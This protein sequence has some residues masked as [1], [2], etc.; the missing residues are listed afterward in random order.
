MIAIVLALA[1][2][3]QGGAAAAR[4]ANGLITGQVRASDNSLPAGVRV[5]A[6]PVP[7]GTIYSDSEALG[8]SA[9]TPVSTTQTDAQ[10]RFR[11]ENVPPGRYLVQGGLANNTTYY[12]GVTSANSRTATVVT[13]TAGQTVENIDFRLQGSLGQRVSGRVHLSEGTSPG[14]AATL[15]GSRIEEF[16]SVP[17]GSD[18]T[19]EFARVPPGLYLL[20]TFPPP[21]GLAPIAVPVRTSD[22][23]GLEL[24]SPPTRNVTGRIVMTNGG[25]IPSGILSFYNTQSYVGATVNG[26]GTFTAKLHAARHQVDVAGMPI[27]Y[28][29]VSV[30]I[31]ST[32]AMGG[33]TVANADVSG[34]VVT[35]SAPPSLPR[36]QGKVTGL[37][38]ARLTSAKVELTGP[39][40][41]TLTASIRPD[42]SFEFPIMIPGLYE[43]RLAGVAEFKPIEVVVTDQPLTTVTL[44]VK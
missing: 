10:G 39:I 40:F 2:W 23:T 9:L 20:S 12:P 8:I 30:R 27:G 17:L 5:A 15:T 13:V 3:Q 24:T 33:F 44:T 29:L 16:L 37:T 11:L 31:G 6:I 28:N 25:P 41:G 21:P 32:D 35:V 43:A 26:D 36:L 14:Q 18:G 7:A 38:G 22:V 4:P 42:G 1:L 34:I 19:F